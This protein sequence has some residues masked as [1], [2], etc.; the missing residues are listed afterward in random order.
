MFS[1]ADRRVDSVPAAKEEGRMCLVGSCPS[2]LRR[3]LMACPLPS[4]AALL[5]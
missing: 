1:E 4:L 3:L 2:K 5:S